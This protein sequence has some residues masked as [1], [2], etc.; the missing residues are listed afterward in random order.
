MLGKGVVCLVQ[1]FRARLPTELPDPRLPSLAG[2]VAAT[3]S[4]AV[5][6][7]RV[8]GEVA[9]EMKPGA[10][11]DQLPI[12]KD[13]LPPPELPL[14]QAA[15]EIK[16]GQVAADVVAKDVKGATESISVR[17]ETPPVVKS[18]GA[19]TVRAETPRV[20]KG[21]GAPTVRAEVPPVAKGEGAPTVRAEV[22]PV[23]K[24][25]GVP[26]VRAETP[27][28]A[29][30]E[31]A[32][33]VRAE[34]A[35]VAKGEGAPTVRGETAPV[36][37]GEAAP[38]VR[39]ETP[40]VAKGEG[41]PAVRGEA[42]PVAEGEAGAVAKGE[43]APRSGAGA[44]AN[45]RAVGADAPVQPPQRPQSIRSRAAQQRRGETKD[46]LTEANRKLKEAE[47]EVASVQRDLDDAKA[48]R[49]SDRDD[50]VV[51]DQLRKD[52]AEK[53]VAAKANRRQA[54]NALKAAENEAAQVELAQKEIARLEQKI[55]E[56]D[57]KMNEVASEAELATEFGGARGVRPPTS[58]KQATKY[59]EI[60]KQRAEAL[61]SLKG[62]TDDL[63]RSLADQARSMTPGPEG[64]V[65]ALQNAEELGKTY[66][67]LAPKKGEPIDV[68]TGK[69][70]EGTWES[71]HIMPRTEIASDP[72]FAALDK[73]GRET[74]L[75]GIPE[76]EFPLAT[77]V[78]R[79]KKHTPLPEWLMNRA[80]AGK[81]VDYTIAEAMREANVK[82]RQAVEAKF[83][84]LIGKIP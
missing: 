45:A 70:I 52:S 29:K 13:P 49:A 81:A 66:D 35:P 50:K 10:H 59:A 64:K 31:T 58:S 55:L 34:T 5:N 42:A 82:A 47:D 78:N 2:D 84:E 14:T 65:R 79:S 75:R 40:P 1:R 72:R 3:E 7:Q 80:K 9:A 32:P 6:A 74:M 71:D 62:R 18:E 19:P 23:A 22:P 57:R 69:P 11:A 43:A 76:N 41:A 38:T 12:A 63:T 26:T 24:G 15:G 48:M 67:V 33:T 21:E 39:G 25:E 61:E 56:L 28:V 73:A 16:P 17:A 44:D 77:L 36:A 53:L 20:A 4:G 27:P 30:G 83:N 37:K 51:I 8:A 46:N 60:E 68:T 54:R